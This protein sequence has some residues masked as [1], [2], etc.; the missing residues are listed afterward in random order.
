M[1][2]IEIEIIGDLR[3][4]MLLLNETLTSYIRRKG[5]N[6]F[7]IESYEV[8]DGFVR[9]VFVESISRTQL[10]GVDNDIL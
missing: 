1:E 2:G 4:K 6:W 9:Y 5:S 3:E 8:E 7:V 10:F